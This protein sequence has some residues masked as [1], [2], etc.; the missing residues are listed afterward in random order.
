VFGVE[1]TS[2]D[3]TQRVIALHNVTGETASVSLKHLVTG[4]ETVS[5]V[6]RDLLSGDT[7]SGSTI[8]IPPYRVKWL[9][10]VQEI[11]KS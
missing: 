5:A 9:K 4:D 6:Y 1:R 8:E 3:G 10:A 7:I 2:P 11:D